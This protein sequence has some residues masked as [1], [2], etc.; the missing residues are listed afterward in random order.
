MAAVEARAGASD[1]PLTITLREE[2]LI[3]RIHHTTRSAV[4]FG[5]APGSRPSNRFDA[6]GGEYRVLYASERLE[7]A[8][9]ETVLRRPRGRVLRRELVNERAWS[10][11]R[12]ERSMLL[13]KVYDEGLQAYEIDAGELGADDYTASRT[14]GLDIYV[15][16]PEIEGLAYRSRYNNGE[17]C[18][19]LFDRVAATDL[20]PTRRERFDGNR[21]TVD[22]L[23]SLYRASFDTSEPVP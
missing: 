16:F 14:L 7:G 23:M 9:V 13:A 22:R 1:A 21:D 12:L 8:F 17:I 2:A 4:F 5:P 18:Y 15:K 20:T 11:L 10:I 3:V 19:A 6:P